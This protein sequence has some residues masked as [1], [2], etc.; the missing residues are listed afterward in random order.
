MLQEQ[1]GIQ[2]H[3]QTYRGHTYSFASGTQQETVPTS[4]RSKSIK[5]IFT[6]LR[7]DN[8]FT[9][10]Q[11]TVS[12]RCKFAMNSLQYKIGSS[13]FPSQNLTTNPQMFAELMKSVGPL[14]DVR[15]GSRIDQRS[16]NAIVYTPVPAANNTSTGFT[17]LDL[18][19]YAGATDILESGLDTATQSLTIDTL[20]SWS[21]ATP[22]AGAAV[23]VNT[24]CLVD[25]I[26]TLSSDGLLTVSM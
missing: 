24:Y 8:M 14:Q 2:W 6:I 15:S 21:A 16:Y 3:G 5:S 23:R 11:A 12:Q 19:T 9:I 13:V 1:G 4:E 10:N 7:P 25:A 26:F 18:E 17:G 20:M 22:G